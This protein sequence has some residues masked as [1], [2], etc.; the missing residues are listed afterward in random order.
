MNQLKPRILSSLSR[1]PNHQQA[2]QAC[3]S[4]HTH[5][6]RQLHTL[7]KFQVFPLHAKLLSNTLSAARLTFIS[8]IFD[9]CFSTAA[10]VARAVRGLRDSVFFPLNQFDKVKLSCSD[11]KTTYEVRGYMSLKKVKTLQT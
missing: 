3:I 2:T 1:L 6:S 5:T 11:I 8:L 7:K 9:K 10:A 4:T